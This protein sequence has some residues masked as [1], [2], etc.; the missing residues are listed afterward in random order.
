[1]RPDAAGSS[2]P[3]SRAQSPS[4]AQARV[5]QQREGSIVRLRV[6]A[7]IRRELEGSSPEA[8]RPEVRPGQ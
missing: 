4:L 7:V 2:A 3:E 1:M 6:K 5:Q 8:E